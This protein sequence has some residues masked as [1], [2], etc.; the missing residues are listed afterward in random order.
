MLPVV[1]CQGLKGYFFTSQYLLICALISSISS[2][3]DLPGF[4]LLK[5]T[6]RIAFVFT[7]YFHN[8]FLSLFGQNRTIILNL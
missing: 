1:C 3:N 5:C 2:K 6:L 7:P 8:P 4:C